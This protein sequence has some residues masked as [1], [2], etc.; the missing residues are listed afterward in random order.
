MQII[1]SFLIKFTHITAWELPLKS[2]SFSQ[3]SLRN[4]L[5]RQ[6]ARYSNVYCDIYDGQTWKQFETVNSRASLQLPN[7]LGLILN[8]DWFKPSKHVEYSIGIMY[9][10]QNV[11]NWRMLLLLVFC[12]VQMSPR[13]TWFH[14][15][16]QPMLAESP[17]RLLPTLVVSC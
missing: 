5:W 15:L 16:N 8:W 1:N 4:E 3:G 17:I 13:N 11:T 12:L 2:Y 9:L 7:N 10:G 6:R 14:I